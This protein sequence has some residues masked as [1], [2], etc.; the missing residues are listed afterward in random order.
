M[1]RFVKQLNLVQRHYINISY[2]K[3]YLN[4]T[5]TV[6]S[7]A[8]LY[9]LKDIIAFSVSMIKKIITLSCEDIS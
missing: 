1:H 2:T 3:F 8:K 7:M 5:N 4:Q 9:S 6:E